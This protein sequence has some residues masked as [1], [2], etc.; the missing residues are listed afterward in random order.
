MQPWSVPIYSLVCPHLFPFIPAEFGDPHTDPLAV[1]ALK[2]LFPTREIVTLNVDVLGA[3]GGGI[4]C[5]T[6]QMPATV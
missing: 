3:I 5:A 1:E 6:Q 2:G 4:H